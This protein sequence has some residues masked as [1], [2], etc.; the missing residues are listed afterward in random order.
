M[1][2]SPKI[3]VFRLR[4]I[5]Y[6]LVLAFLS[7]LLILCLVWM[8]KEK[9]NDSALT[10]SATNESQNTTDTVQ[11]NTDATETA[12]VEATPASSGTGNYIAGVY[13]S[14]LVLGDSSVDVQVTVDSDKI[15]AIELVNLSEATEASY[16]LVISSFDNLVSQIIEKQKLDGITCSTQNRYT[17][18][19]L[20]N[21]I[22][23][24]LKTAQTPFDS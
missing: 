6:T 1:S 8:F 11:K 2:S 4:E 9:G 19:L 15:K 7:I 5:V 13:T 14:P 10:Q 16:P 17:S 22:S 24:A 18:Q 12:S 3:M 23:N 20:L 21:A